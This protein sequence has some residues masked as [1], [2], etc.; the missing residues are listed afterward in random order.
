MTSSDL[1]FLIEFTWAQVKSM[2]L[3]DTTDYSGITPVVLPE[4]ITGYIKVETPQAIIHNNLNTG[5]GLGT[6]DIFGVDNL[7]SESINLPVTSAGK[8]VKGTYKFTYQARYWQDGV[9]VALS[10]LVAADKTIY[11]VGDVEAAVQAALGGLFLLSGTPS[12]DGVVTPISA[13]Y[14]AIAGTTAIV[15]TEAIHDYG[16]GGTLTYFESYDDYQVT[17]QYVYDIDEPTVAIEVSANCLTSQLVSKDITDYNIVIDGVVHA[18]LQKTLAHKITPPAGSGFPTPST[19][20]TSF[21]TLGPNIWTQEWIVQITT[22]LLYDL[23]VDP[24]GGSP[25]FTINMAISGKK[26]LDVKC[27]GCMCTIYNCLKGIRDKYLEARSGNN[28]SRA[29][30]LKRLLDEIQRELIL[31]WLGERCGEDID[32]FCRKVV[33]YI[34]MEDCSCSYTDTDV[35]TEIL[36]MVGILGGYTININNGGQIFTGNGVPI[37][38]LGDDGDLYLDVDSG[39]VYH[40]VNGVWIYQTN[41]IGPQGNTV[42]GPTGPQGNTV[43]GPT[44]PAGQDVTGP[45]GPQGN[46]VTGPT[47]PQGATVTGPAGATVTGPAGV[48]PL[49]KLA[50]S[51]VEIASAATATWQKLV[52][53]ALA[54]GTLIYT[55]DEVVL[56]AIFDYIGTVGDISIRAGLKSLNDVTIYMFEG[57]IVAAGNTGIYRLMLKVSVR[58]AN[59]GPAELNYYAETLQK[60]AATTVPDIT[61]M[62]MQ[63]VDITVADA[64]E[65]WVQ[66]DDGNAADITL[67]EY[68]IYVINRP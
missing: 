6:V 67:R 65:I 45:T 35:S 55:G 18:P 61:E 57:T 43:T 33:D 46:T 59:A 11:H 48:N 51:G 47:G 8:I 30:D 53:S 31:Y 52:T 15:L 5:T 63:A 24:W 20:T 3:Q 14:D 44:G 17:Q 2:T 42:T 37:P 13:T 28:L 58:D 26:I 12:D 27:S 4:H 62:V 49:L 34:N 29:E 32:E 25:W 68:G 39:N 60:E 41:M 22:Q 23:S 16:S 64:M 7:T 50:Y 10:A 19:F 36:P 56:E 40:K 66:S 9:D 1:R 54:G 38:A 21:V